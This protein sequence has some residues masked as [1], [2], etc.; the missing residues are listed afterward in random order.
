[1][2]RQ[3]Y[4]DDRDLLNPV[5]IKTHDTTAIYN[6]DDTYKVVKSDYENA[7]TT[8]YDNQRTFHLLIYD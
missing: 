8:I 4:I 6:N 5:K 1:M 3:V 2:F 7:V